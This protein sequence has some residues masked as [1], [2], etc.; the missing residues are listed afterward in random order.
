[1]NETVGCP[2]CSKELKYI[3]SNH[4]KLHNINCKKFKEL[5][6]NSN[7]Y[8]EKYLHEKSITDKLYREN[9]K[10]MLDNYF[11]DY[12]KINSKKRCEYQ[13]QYRLDNIEKVKEREKIYCGNTKNK[14]RKYDK[15]YRKENIKKIKLK[16]KEY[17]ENN[18]DKK[19]KREREYHKKNPHI[20]AWRQVLLNSL[21]GMGKKKEGHTIDLLGY[22]ATELKN[23]LESLFTEG[24]SWDNHGEWHIDHINAVNNFEP[25]TPPN[26]VNNLNNLQ[27]LWATTREINGILYLGNLNKNKY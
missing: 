24:M 1:M 27:P 10:E 3:S 6:P 9:N 19:N 12:R 2:I 11:S 14:K 17:R 23:H 26:I 18:R 4:L 15:Q 16:Q 22:S 13:K 5:Y 25:N 21:R 7:I 20:K 8:S